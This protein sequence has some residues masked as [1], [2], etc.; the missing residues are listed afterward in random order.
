MLLLAGNPD[1]LARSHSRLAPHVRNGTAF[2]MGRRSCSI[3][4]PS[5]EAPLPVSIFILPTDRLHEIDDLLKT[6][7]ERSDTCFQV[8]RTFRVGASLDGPEHQLFFV[9]APWKVLDLLTVAL[10]ERAIPFGGFLYCEAVPLPL[11][12]GSSTSPD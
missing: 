3:P 7:V 10:R 2:R 12:P 1:A 9:E 11:I 5:S 8:D 4:M 6:L